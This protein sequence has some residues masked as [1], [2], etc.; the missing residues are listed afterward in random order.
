LLPVKVEKRMINP[1]FCPKII[2]THPAFEEPLAGR[3]A[4]AFNIYCRGKHKAKV[5]GI[6]GICTVE[7]K[8]VTGEGMTD[9]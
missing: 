1:G 9:S 5:K 7:E 3:V 2:S 8:K 6:F 4:V